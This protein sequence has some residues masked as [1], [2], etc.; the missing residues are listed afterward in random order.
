MNPLNDRIPE[1]QEKRIEGLIAL[2]QQTYRQEQKSP[3][4]EQQEAI[5]RVEARLART[6]ENKTPLAKRVPEERAGSFLLRSQS[7]SARGKSMMQVISALAAVLVVSALISGAVLL[8]TQHMHSHTV[9]RLGD[10]P[11]P[12]SVVGTPTLTGPEGTPVLVDVKWDG[13]EMSMSV[14]PG[15]YFLGELLAVDLSLTNHTHPTLTLAGG[16][17]PSPCGS[18]LLPQQTGGTA[19]YYPLYTMPVPLPP[20]PCPFAQPGMGPPLVAGQT[21]TGLFYEPLTSSGDVTLTCEVL[22]YLLET[23]PQGVAGWQE[24]A[25][26]LA[27]HLPILQIHVTPQAPADR[28]LSLQQEGSEAVIDVPASIALLERTYILCQDSQRDLFADG[29]RPDIWNPLATRVLQ[30]PACPAGEK[31]VQ[32]KYAIGAV[33]Y[34]IAQGQYI[35]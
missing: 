1:E 20:L 8:F 28:T 24:G 14:T 17:G 19:P 35:G 9:A 32:W 16:A 26:P 7:E 23:S 12:T 21:V 18:A 34:V 22:F 3:E 4:S 27:G 2:L 13:L 29:D 6:E 25:G 11:V 15:P 33:G 10:T 30:R 31:V 5:A